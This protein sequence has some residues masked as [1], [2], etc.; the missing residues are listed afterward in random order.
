ME[1][2]RPHNRAVSH[3]LRD[4]F[5]QMLGGIYT[6]EDFDHNNPDDAIVIEPSEDWVALVDAAV[7]ADDIKAVIDR[8][9]GRDELTDDIRT[10][11]LTRYGML[12]RELTPE[13]VVDPA[14][15]EYVAGPGE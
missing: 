4:A 14:A 10:R 1:R 2:I 15:P 8:C 7:T 5:P 12:S 13:R 6:P 11:A 9:R 3:A